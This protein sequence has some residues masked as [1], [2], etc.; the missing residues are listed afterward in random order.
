MTSE[1]PAMAKAKASR[2]LE[3]LRVFE[4][5][6]SAPVGCFADYEGVKI[7]RLTEGL[8]VTAHR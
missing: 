6:V 4:D 8:L 7:G 1:M 3:N 2:F 5:G